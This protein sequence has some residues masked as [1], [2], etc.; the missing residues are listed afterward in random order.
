MKRLGEDVQYTVGYRQDS[1]DEPGIYHAFLTLDKTRV[2]IDA[3]ALAQTAHSSKP[4]GL[5][6]AGKGN[7]IMQ[8]PEQAVSYTD[9]F[10]RQK[11][12]AA[13]P[14]HAHSNK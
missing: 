1:S 10:G 13:A 4:L 2:I 9:I 3:Y 11:T 8:Q 12:Y 5:M 6:L 7:A 14:M